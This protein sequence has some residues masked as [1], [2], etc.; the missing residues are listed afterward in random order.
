LVKVTGK[1]TKKGLTK[2][3]L[4]I[5]YRNITPDLKHLLKGEVSLKNGHE[6]GVECG[7]FSPFWGI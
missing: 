1:S 2:R 7:Y 3:A 4:H 5:V 6:K